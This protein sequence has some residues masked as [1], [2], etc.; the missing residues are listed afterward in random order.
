MICSEF[1]ALVPRYL[2]GDLA[3]PL[4]GEFEQHY[5]QCDRCFS[6]LQVEE[7]LVNKEFTVNTGNIIPIGT[8]SMVKFLAAAAS[9]V[10]VAVLSVFY[11]SN[12]NYQKRLYEASQFT[13]PSFITS[14]SRHAGQIG[15]FMAAMDFY[16]EGQYEQARVILEKIPPGKRDMPVVFFQGVC[17]LL[18][19]DHNA[20][21]RQFNIII[22]DMNPSYY[23][24]AI[25]YKAIA[26]LRLDK[27]AKAKELLYNLTDMLS[28]FACKSRA[29]LE[30]VKNL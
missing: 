8:R 9:F 12:A 24:E 22:S 27:I 23:D 29:M 17:H 18:E 4:L 2:K 1:S 7:K 11:F 25:Y 26:L 16:K 15:P 19:E 20:A 21:I 6:D 3:D 28:P 10:L 5:F 13:A 14:E 30:K